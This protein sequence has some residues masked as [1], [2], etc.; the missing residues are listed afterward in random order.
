M[1]R[2]LPNVKRGPLV[3]KGYTFAFQ[4]A[5]VCWLDLLGY[6]ASIAEAGFN[7]CTQGS[8]GDEAIASLP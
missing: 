8:T 7:Q 2:Q 5:A 6:G 3:R 4:T 1:T